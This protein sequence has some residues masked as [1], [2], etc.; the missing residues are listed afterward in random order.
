[1]CIRDSS[2]NAAADFIEADAVTTSTGAW[3]TMTFD[4]GS[5]VGGAF[6]PAATYDRISIFPNFGVSG[7]NG[8][9]G[10][11]YVDDIDMAP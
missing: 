3:E 11:W 8:G 1:M 7:P 6:N 2:S 9:D 10:I 4:F 5:P